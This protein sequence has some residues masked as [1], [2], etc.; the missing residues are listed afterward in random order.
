MAFQRR[1]TWAS[2]SPPEGGAHFC[3]LIVEQ[4][5]FLLHWPQF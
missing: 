4:G 1:S 5:P 2:L 3:L